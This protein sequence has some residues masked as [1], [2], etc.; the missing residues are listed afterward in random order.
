MLAF[1]N[2]NS[3]SSYRRSTCLVKAAC[4]GLIICVCFYKLNVRRNLITSAGYRS[5]IQRMSV[6]AKLSLWYE[7]NRLGHW[8]RL[9][10]VLLGGG[11]YILI[12]DDCV[13]QPIV[14][15]LTIRWE[16]VT[17]NSLDWIQWEPREP[18][19][20][21]GKWH[22]DRTGSTQLPSGWNIHLHTKEEKQ[23]RVSTKLQYTLFLHPSQ[24]FD[25]LFLTSPPSSL[26]VRIPNAN[27]PGVWPLHKYDQVQ[28]NTKASTAERQASRV[29]AGWLNW[30]SNE[31]P[32]ESWKKRKFTSCMQMR[33]IRVTT[34]LSMRNAK[35]RRHGVASWWST[36]TIGALSAAMR[37]ASKFNL[38]GRDAASH[39]TVDNSR[40]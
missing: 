25:Y 39:S 7:A 40:L 28:S 18:D 26:T 21:C 29:V 32:S 22:Q 17:R 2:Y 19:I 9:L 36:P 10:V 33:S 20:N 5:I 30:M 37:A 27:L 24:L 12:D 23:E 1:L 11:M 14:Q 8:F 16:I 38:V 3:T 31:R 13:R 15:C 4:F 34:A 6:W 35:K